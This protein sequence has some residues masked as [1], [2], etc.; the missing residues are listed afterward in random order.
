MTSDQ[1]GQTFMSQSHLLLEVLELL[2]VAGSGL[3]AHLLAGPLKGAVNLLCEVHL[4][5]Q[6]GPARYYRCV[7]SD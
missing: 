2:R 7:V 5:S 3:G 6:S 1:R 4:S